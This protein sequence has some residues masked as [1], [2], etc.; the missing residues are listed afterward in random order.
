[1]GNVDG[2]ALGRGRDRVARLPG[3]HF[4]AEWGG[5]YD[6]DDPD[7]KSGLHPPGEQWAH[8]LHRRAGLGQQPS[9]RRLGHQRQSR[10]RRRVASTVRLTR[11][12]ARHSCWPARTPSTWAGTSSTRHHLDACTRSRNGN[13]TLSINNPTYHPGFAMFPPEKSLFRRRRTGD[14]PAAFRWVSLCGAPER[15]PIVVAPGRGS[16]TRAP[17]DRRGGAH[18]QRR[19]VALVVAVVCGLP[20]LARPRPGRHAPPARARAPSPA[21]P[22]GATRSTSTPLGPGS[23]SSSPPT[24][25]S[26]SG[27]R[28][29]AS[30]PIRPTRH[31]TGRRPRRRRRREARLPRREPPGVRRRG[32]LPPPDPLAGA[33]GLQGAAALRPLPARRHHAD[34]GGGRRPHLGRAPAPRRSC[35]GARRSSSSAGA[36]RTA[37]SPTGTRPSRWRSATTGTTAGT[38]TPS[39]LRQHRRLRR[40]A[41]HAGARLVLV[42]RPGA[43]Q[44]RGAPLRRLL[45]RGRH[46][47]T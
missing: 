39:L 2:D 11:P 19:S 38:P 4:D 16:T 7:L 34:L 44:P 3:G 22:F 26:A 6:P 10:H 9:H 33:A 29:T 28:P 12:R 40:P 13:A 42:R 8:G 27:W 36:C 30:S 23:R 17:W 5:P 43:G 45:L 24:T 41:Q 15:S 21:S 25:C 47:S 1:M 18:R 35:P 37:G 31:P 32:L 20:L 46:A 14:G